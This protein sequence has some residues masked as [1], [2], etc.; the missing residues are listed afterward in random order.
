[1]NI[2]SVE[3]YYFTTGG[4]SRVFFETKA[5]LERRGHRVIPF[6]GRYPQNQPSPFGRYF[7]PR[8][9]RF[10]EAD[11]SRVPWRLYAKAF[12]DAVYA[13][14]AAR[15]V[16]RIVREQGPDL[17][18]LHTLFYQLSPSVIRALKSRGVPVVQT[19]H[20]F[21]PWCANR[22]FYAHGRICEKCRGHRYR[23]ILVQN[24]CRGGRLIGAMSF[25]AN[26]AYR[27]LDLYPRGVDL[28]IAPSEFVRATLVAWGIPGRRIVKIGH[29][30]P[31]G[32]FEEP[33]IGTDG[34][35]LFAGYLSRAKGIFTLVKAARQL[36]RTSF[37]V[38]GRGPDRARLEAEIG[39]LG[40]ANVRLVGFQDRRGLAALIAGSRAVVF[41]SECPETFGLGI[42]ESFALGKPV[43]A[44]A[45]GAYPE[46]VREG[47]TGALFGAGDAEDLARALRRLEERPVEAEEMGR[48][49]RVQSRE[50]YGEEEHFIKL[51]AA[52]DSVR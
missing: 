4:A 24:C 42:L 3:K 18:H 14:D 2:L 47:E 46:L 26:V 20:D 13:V 30:L 12:R 8:F 36:P 11:R 9:T 31:G 19:V 51:M 52:Y 49:A 15:A 37:V 33:R 43:V 25:C 21:A 50:R 6:A 27:W 10:L 17:A 29:F 38:A 7:V 5:L 41:P 34:Y 44:S 39:R 40:L 35:F 22:S 1:M 45:L 23:Q 16:T 32:W 48:N 28:F